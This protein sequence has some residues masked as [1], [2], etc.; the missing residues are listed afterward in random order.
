MLA[1]S[2]PHDVTKTGRGKFANS[3][4]TAQALFARPHEFAVIGHLAVQELFFLHVIDEI[5]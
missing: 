2:L 4:K 5:C 3:G 1:F